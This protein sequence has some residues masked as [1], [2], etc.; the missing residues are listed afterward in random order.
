MK[1]PMVGSYWV[2]KTT[3]KEYKVIA[4]GLCEETLE[5]CVVYVSLDKE[6]KCW[7]RPLE[8]FMDGRF[9]DRPYS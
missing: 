2:H 7:I 3:L 8:I 9:Y 1:K 6:Q 4:V 5:E